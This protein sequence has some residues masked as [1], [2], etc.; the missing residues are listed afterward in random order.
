MFVRPEREVDAALRLVEKGLND[1]QVSH[2]TGLPR[3]TIRNWR[4]GGAP[5]GPLRTGYRID[6][7]VTH[8][9]WDERSYSYLLGAYL[10]DGHIATPGNASWLRVYL[11]AKYRE[12]IQECAGAMLA[13]LPVTVRLYNRITQGAVVVHAS[14]HNWPRLFPQHGPGKK[15][16]RRIVLE[17]WQREITDAFP[18]ELLRGLIHSDGSRCINRFSTRLPSGRVSH[19]AYPRYFFTNFS[20]DIREIF[21]EHCELLGIHWTRSN[22]KNISISHRDSVACLDQFV[23]SKA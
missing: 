14:S 1:S 2:E 9:P 19:Y 4:V 6:Q 22:W 7:T 11:D 23:G 8:R 21:C 12:I 15:H 10:G 5:G 13:V 3:S 20:K 18:E 17:P 16:E